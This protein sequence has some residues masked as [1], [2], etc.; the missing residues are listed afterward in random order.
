[1][2]DATLTDETA[3]TGT[4]AIE[5]PEAAEILR[6]L[7]TSILGQLPAGTH[8]AAQ[9]QVPGGAIPCRVLRRSQ[10]GFPGAELVL[11]REALAAAW[12]AL[13]AAV[14]A[15]GGS[16]IGYRAL[17]MLRLEAGIPWFGAR[18]RRTPDS[19]GGGDRIHAHQLHQG[20]LHGTGD[21]GARALARARQPAA[22]R[23]RVQRRRRS[24]ARY[25]D[26]RR[27]GKRSDPAKD[28]K[29]D[30]LRA[31]RFRRCSGR[32]SEWLTCAANTCAPGTKLQYGR[33][34]DARRSDRTAAAAAVRRSVPKLFV[35]NRGTSKFG[36]AERPGIRR[37]SGPSSNCR[38]RF[39]SFSATAGFRKAASR[40]AA[41]SRERR[42]PP[43]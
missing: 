43:E 37:G 28:P 9:M 13:G 29:P 26:F 31:P 7:R 4:L 18:F 16:P 25:G 10:F 42:R 20:L 15:R 38:A 41:G 35:L 34:G 36:L 17:D 27:R 6:E 33:R 24:E 8:V 19:A 22:G 23:I 2:D 3:Q 40:D 14:R 21:R 30:T 11:P 1:M 39:G 32:P 12:Q 5:G